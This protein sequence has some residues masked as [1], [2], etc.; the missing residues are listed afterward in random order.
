V[1]S[2]PS[3]HPIAGLRRVPLAAIFGSSSETETGAAGS[4]LCFVVGQNS[5]VRALLGR[6]TGVVYLL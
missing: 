2:A 1:T 5:G 3:D 6:E 4:V